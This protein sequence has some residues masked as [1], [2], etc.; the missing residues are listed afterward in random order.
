M[1]FAR[2]QHPMMVFAGGASGFL[3]NVSSF[4]LVK[5][6]SSMTLKTMTMARNGGLVLVS[7]L[8]FGESVTLLEASPAL[9][10]AADSPA[11]SLPLSRARV[12]PALPAPSSG[13]A[14]RQAIGYSGLLLAFGMY[15]YFKYLEGA[16]KAPCAP[17]WPAAKSLIT[18]SRGPSP[19]ASP[20]ARRHPFRSEELARALSAIKGQEELEEGEPL[21]AGEG[22]H[23]RND[24]QEDDGR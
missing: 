12:S 19:M 10:P 13:P 3:V 16:A 5:R 9:P 20:A 15:T 6:T 14:P 23:L 17:G 11:R 7:A 8:V 18:P 2:V 21:S 4:L 1:P 22:E 24:D